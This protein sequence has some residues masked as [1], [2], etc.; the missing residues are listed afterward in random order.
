MQTIIYTKWQCLRS[1]SR[2]LLNLNYSSMGIRFLGDNRASC[3]SSTSQ[4]SVCFLCFL[5][6]E[7]IPRCVQGLLRSLCSGIS[8]V[9]LSGLY[10]VLGIKH[11][12]SHLQGKCLYTVHLCPHFVVPKGY[13]WN[14]T[15]TDDTVSS[16]TCFSNFFFSWWEKYFSLFIPCTFNIYHP[17]NKRQSYGKGEYEDLQQWKVLQ[18]L[19]MSFSGQLCHSADSQSGLDKEFTVTH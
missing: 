2:G 1:S 18:S 8:S 11:R 16:W 5:C 3:K 19:S 17:C 6:L 12:V 9:D 13:L 14:L 15:S 10:M 4:V 7:I